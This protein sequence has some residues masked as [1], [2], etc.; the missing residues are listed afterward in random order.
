MSLDEGL[1]KSYDK[2]IKLTQ[3]LT[4][5][6]LVFSFIFATLGIIVISNSFFTL[7]FIF[8]LISFLCIVNF[9]IGNNTIFLLLNRKDFIELKK[10][11]V[12]K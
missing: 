7:G 11:V 3:I 8:L 10:W 5:L 2:G 1:I 9:N 6:D 4:W 12:K